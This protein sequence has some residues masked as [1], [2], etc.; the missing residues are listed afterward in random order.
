MSPTPRAALVIVALALAALVLPVS[1]TLTLGLL[2]AVAIVADAWIARRPLQ[3]STSVPTIL[4]RGVPSPLA[5]AT[6]GDAPERV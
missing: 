4:A 3:L 6:E 2:V 1:V 5:V